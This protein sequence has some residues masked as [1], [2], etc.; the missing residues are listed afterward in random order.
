[1]PEYIDLS[2]IINEDTAVYPGDDKIKLYQNKF[3]N[4]HKYNDSKLE[5]GMHVGTHIDAPSHLTNNN[6]YISDYPIDKF[7]GDGV[8]LDVRNENIIRMKDK[9][10]EA[11]KDGDIVLLY[12]GFS[13]DF[14]SENYF[15]NHPIIEKQLAEF[16]ISK[17][18]K[19]IGL[20]FPSP[21]N[22]P[23]EIHTMLLS[24]N[25]LILENLVNLENLSEID[26]FEIMAFPLKIKAEGSPIRV[27]AK[28]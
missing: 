15:E 13:K 16:F 25:I 17:N 20:D 8:L 7:I 21:D 5:T 2:H 11:V 4:K 24:N 6:I 3:I 27:V 26:V 18:I 12:T 22:Y 19:M 10:L 28:I 14:G 9:Y 23:F 1:M